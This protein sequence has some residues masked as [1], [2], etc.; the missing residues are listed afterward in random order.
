MESIH[1]SQEELR[2]KTHGQLLEEHILSFNEYMKHWG[3]FL[4]RAYEV[5]QK[6]KAD[7]WLLIRYV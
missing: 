6:Y 7:M 3:E 2:A 1:F 4:K 5:H